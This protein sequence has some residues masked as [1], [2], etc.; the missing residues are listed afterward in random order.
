MT[1]SMVST[2]SVHE[3]RCLSYNL[4]VFDTPLDKNRVIE[5]EK[6]KKIGVFYLMLVLTLTLSAQKLDGRLT[7][8][9]P[10][11]DASSATRRAQD[12]S[13]V[14]HRQT[15]QAGQNRQTEWPKFDPQAVRRRMNVTFNPDST[16][17]S[18]SVIARLKPGAT[19]PTERLREMGIEVCIEAGR[20][21]TLQVP[22]QS[23]YL[24]EG[25]GEIERVEADKRRR[26][27][28]DAAREA[29]GVDALD[30]TDATAWQVLQQTGFAHRTSP[31]SGQGV[32]V[33]VI[34]GGIDFNHAAFRDSEGHSRVKRAILIEDDGK[35]GT[36]HLYTDPDEIAA[37]TTDDTGESHGTHVA[38]IAAGS[39][40]ASY[41]LRPVQGMAPGADLLLCGL[42]DFSYDSHI[43]AAIKAAFDYA[44]QQTKAQG[45]LVPLVLNLSM[46]YDL[47]A[48][49]GNAPS[50]LLAN[51]LT[52]NGT[53]PGRIIVYA[54]GNSGSSQCFVTARLGKKD[55]DG[56]QLRLL[57]SEN[58]GTNLKKKI[59]VGGITYRSGYPNGLSAYLY[60]PDG[61]EFDFDIVAVDTLTGKVY[62]L[63]EKPLYNAKGKPFDLFTADHLAQGFNGEEGEKYWA[64]IYV[65]EPIYFLDANMRLGIQ[66]KEQKAA[67]QTVVAQCDESI[68]NLFTSGG[69]SGYTPGSGQNS[70]TT[71]VCTNSVISVG[72]YVSRTQWQP[73]YTHITGSET[74]IGY[75]GPWLTAN[76]GICDFSSYGTDDNGITRPDI[77]APGS[78][79][80]SAYNSYDRNYFTSRRPKNTRDEELSDRVSLGGTNHFYGVMCGTS[81]SSPCAAGIIALWLEQEPTLSVADVRKLLHSTA[82]TDAYTTD[83]ALIPS[84]NLLQAAHG[85][86]NALAG[87][88]QL[89]QT[90][91]IAAPLPADSG[92]SAASAWF[93]LQGTPLSAPPSLPG[94]YL[95]RG[96]KVWVK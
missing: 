87:M 76:G 4:C 29:T 49:D 85:K 59:T 11:P 32:V 14:G 91:A 8:L 13:L 2:R 1:I 3:I 88:Q 27:M 15:Q 18:L 51:E 73:Y 20:M 44:D 37:L 21:A 58:D 48:K 7:S 72:A 56:Y 81:M 45:H 52:E 54:A 63:D 9:V 71:D 83:P 30:G 35:E 25:V 5:T 92:F 10:R 64:E 77:L 38:A 79:L 39:P 6:M 86:I 16:V 62:S 68:Y 41:T 46:G 89:V 75:P 34:D 67:N 24:L 61:P 47:G 19:C 96:K 28:N 60:T 22:A 69:L 33:G 94:I 84:G 57:L 80:L 40:V 53:K 93:T 74:Y 65:D 31:Y 70:F 82:T 95:Y 12:A 78:A 43:M 17:R 50:C 66:V 23:L 55:S 26:L 42:G 90:T 36:M